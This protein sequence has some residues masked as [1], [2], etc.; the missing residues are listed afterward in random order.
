MT[1]GLTLGQGNKVIVLEVNGDIGL[2]TSDGSLVHG[3]GT[4]LEIEGPGGCLVGSVLDVE[5]EDTL[6]FLDLILALGLGHG[7]EVLVNLGEEG[8]GLE[9][10]D[11][12][13]C[14]M[15]VVIGVSG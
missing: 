3:T 1:V 12:E 7:L 10:F 14:V 4:G 5:L 2:E 11:V 9:T 13:S 8:R 6:D 15:I